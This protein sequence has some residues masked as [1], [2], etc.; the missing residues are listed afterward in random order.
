MQ[1]MSQPTPGHDDP[2]AEAAMRAQ[3]ALNQASGLP[4]MGAVSGTASKQAGLSRHCLCMADLCDTT[5]CWYSSSTRCMLLFMVQRAIS[6]GLSHPLLRAC[7]ASVS[8]Q[9]D[10]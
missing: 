2:L 9:V 4:A 5:C 3:G 6:G 8:G 7:D 1:A 10:G